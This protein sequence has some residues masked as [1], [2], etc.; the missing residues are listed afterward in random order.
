MQNHEKTVVITFGTFSLFHIGHLKILQRAKNLGDILIVGI[1]SDELNK[2]KKDFY[3]VIPQHERI[4]I[5]QALKC[6]DQVFIEE[7]LEKKIEYINFYQANILV[8]GDDWLGKFDFVQEH[9]PCLK[10]IV[11][12]PR[13]PHISSTEIELFIKNKK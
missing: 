2:H 11:Y 5:V 12:L 4:E 10:K 3:P 8:M 7:S 6:V 1:S 9:C 13:T